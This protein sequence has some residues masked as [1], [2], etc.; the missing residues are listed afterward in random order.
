[1]GL[2]WMSLNMSPALNRICLLV[3]LRFTKTSLPA[4]SKHVVVQGTAKHH[5][6]VTVKDIALGASDTLI[7][8]DDSS[9]SI[10]PLSDTRRNH[11]VSISLLSYSLSNIFKDGTFDPTSDLSFYQ[12]NEF[13]H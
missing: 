7:T 1:M 12:M 2:T 5:W 8:T 4:S 9:G 11:S 6:I 10:L 3:F 13:S